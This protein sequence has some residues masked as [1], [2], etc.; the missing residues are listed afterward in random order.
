MA[1]RGAA[2]AR[3]GHA[4][5]VGCLQLPFGSVEQCRHFAEPPLGCAA[6]HGL[7]GGR[8]LRGPLRAIAAVQRIVQRQPVVALTDSVLRALE[9]LDRGLVLLGGKTIGARGARGVD[10][11][12]GLIHFAG[13][14]RGARDGKRKGTEEYRNRHPR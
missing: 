11:P 2:V 8:F 14:R 1:V 3:L 6:Q 10:R 4:R 5:G 7:L 13:G 12:L 9:R